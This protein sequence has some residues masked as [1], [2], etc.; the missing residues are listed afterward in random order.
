[1]KKIG[2]LGPRGT[3]TEMAAKFLFPQD[4]RIPLK[5]I[6]R[7]IDLAFN[8]GTDYAVVPIENAIEGTVN[9]TLDYLIH[10][11]PMPIVGA[12][13]IGIAHHLLSAS[14]KEFASI[15]PKKIISHPQAL[16][17]CH[18]FIQ[19]HFPDVI[20]EHADS[21]AQAAAW[22][23]KH[24]QDDVCVIANREAANLY[25]LSIVAE[26]I[27]DYRENQ[28]RFLVVSASHQQEQL[29]TKQAHVGEVTTLM[30]T[31]P[32]DFT[33]ALHQVL[34]AFAW[35]KLN[36][37]KIESRPTKTGLGNYF[38]IIDVQQL[39]DDVLLPGAIAELNALGCKVDV[40]GS[41]CTYSDQLTRVEK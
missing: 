27:H 12:V 34:S 13:S 39:M 23:A 32:S 30:V 40:L 35:R 22:L 9:V 16:A 4:E 29:V 7:T 1:M 3:F 24:Q 38:F 14:R 8:K 17:Q 20:V 5:T 28:T 31:L 2:F 36:L 18:A 6:P 10:Q 26:D 15:A 33:G 19:E 25:G 21:T 41:Y 37:S 11:K